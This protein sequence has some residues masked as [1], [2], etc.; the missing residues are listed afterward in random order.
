[1]VQNLQNKIIL[2]F[3]LTVCNSAIILGQNTNSF[4]LTVQNDKPLNRHGRDS[5]Q[6]RKDSIYKNNPLCQKYTEIVKLDTLYWSLYP[7]VDLDSIQQLKGVTANE[8]AKQALDI[9]HSKYYS[10]QPFNLI[11]TYS[12]KEMRNNTNQSQNIK[13]KVMVYD[14]GFTSNNLPKARTEKCYNVYKWPDISP[15]IADIW[16]TSVFGEY[17]HLYHSLDFDFLRM[18]SFPGSCD[19]EGDM[20]IWD[21]RKTFDR[22][23]EDYRY[24]KAFKKDSSVYVI[25]D[26]TRRYSILDIA[27]KPNSGFDLHIPKYIIRPQTTEYKYLL[28]NLSTNAIEKTGYYS[29]Q[30]VSTI[31]T[32]VI[33]YETSYKLIDNQYFLNQVTTNTFEFLPNINHISLSGISF[34]VDSVINEPSKVIKIKESKADPRKVNYIDH[35]ISLGVKYKNNDD[36]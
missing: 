17:S 2:I 9:K 30:F 25:L 33:S 11:G 7:K 22:V 23:P 26:C 18:Y 4:S 8:L 6:S 1:M 20:R 27:E 3:I 14:P 32:G 16:K 36:K 12:E 15:T 34:K 31:P 29:G 24:Y 13:T 35:C 21:N 28:I 5:I 19:L 10:N